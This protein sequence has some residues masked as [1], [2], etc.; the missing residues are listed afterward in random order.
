MKLEW[1]SC[2]KNAE[3]C[4]KP[5]DDEIFKY[6]ATNIKSN[7]RELEGAFNRIIA[8][9]KIENQSEITMELAEDA[10]KDIINPDKPKGNHPGTDYRSRCGT[11]RR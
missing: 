9:S 8:K 1:R 5:V 10:L 6:I 4:N 7:I 2:C 11:L 3:A